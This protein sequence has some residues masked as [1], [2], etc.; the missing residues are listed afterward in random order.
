M[1][2]GKTP[3]GTDPT[4]PGSILIDRLQGIL[5]TAGV[6]S[7]AGREKWGENSLVDFDVLFTYSSNYIF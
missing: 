1:A 7:A 6:I 4:L 5:R 3:Q 2:A